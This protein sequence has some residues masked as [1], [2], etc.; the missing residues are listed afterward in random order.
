M[1]KKI[2]IYNGFNFHY[3]MFGYIIHY[4]KTKNYDLTIYSDDN[5]GYNDYYKSL[6]LINEYR[7]VTLFY[8]ERQI[9]DFI[10]LTTDDDWS[11]KTEDSEINRKTICIDHYFKIRNPVFENRIATRPYSREYYRKWALPLYPIDSERPYLDGDK[12]HVVFLCDDYKYNIDIVKRLKSTNPIIFHAI[13][14]S[15]TIDKFQGLDIDV[16]IY[17][18]IDMKKLVEIISNASYVIT[19]LALIKT[20]KHEGMSGSIPLAFGTLTPLIISKESNAYYKFKNVIEFD[21]SVEPILLHDINIDELKKERDELI[22]NN[23]NLFD[24]II[25]SF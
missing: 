23:N 3:E 25:E 11:Y 18:S 20:H 13:S 19:D 5:L 14:R 9:Y 1:S 4:C 12:T 2:A 15:M 8:S 21:N 16:R 24:S 7:P 10:F 17:R 6:Y 22:Q